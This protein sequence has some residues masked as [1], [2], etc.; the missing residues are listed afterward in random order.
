MSSSDGDRAA[1][2]ATGEASASAGAAPSTPIV[3][4]VPVRLH[5]G[6]EGEVDENDNA[7]LR[8]YAA[9]SPVAHALRRNSLLHL[10]QAAAAEAAADSQGQPAGSPAGDD[11]EES[12]EEEERG[13]LLRHQK[14]PKKQSSSS[15]ATRAGLGGSSAT[16]G[17]GS[18]SSSAHSSRLKAGREYCDIPSIFNS[19]EEDMDY[20]RG[21]EEPLLGEWQVRAAAAVVRH[22][23]STQNVYSASPWSFC[24]LSFRDAAAEQAFHYY[25]S[26]LNEHKLRRRLLLLNF[27]YMIYA[28]IEWGTRTSKHYS[29][30]AQSWI[31]VLRVFYIVIN[32]IIFSISFIRR[33][34]YRRNINTA[35][36]ILTL[37]TSTLIIWEGH[38]LRNIYSPF[39][40]IVLI[41]YMVGS[42]IYVRTLFT[43][44][45]G[46]CWYNLILYNFVCLVFNPTGDLSTLHSPRAALVQLV[47]YDLIL[48][49]FILTIMYQTRRVE[50]QARYGFLV[51]YNEAEEEEKQRE[52]E[53]QA[54][55]SA[56][57]GAGRSAQEV[58]SQAAGIE[59]ARGSNGVGTQE[60]KESS[61]I[62]QHDFALPDPAIP[63]ASSSGS[64]A[65]AVAAAAARPHLL[66]RTKAEELA[67]LRELNAHERAEDPFFFSKI[68]RHFL[69]RKP[70]NAPTAANR[71]S[72]T[73]RTSS[74][75][76]GR[77]RDGPNIGGIGSSSGRDREVDVMTDADFAGLI[78]ASPTLGGF[79]GPS[80]DG[81]DTVFSN[82]PLYSTL[83]LMRAKGITSMSDFIRHLS[84]QAKV[85]RAEN[86]IRD[87]PCLCCSSEL[88]PWFTNY[89]YVQTM[90]RANYTAAMCVRSIFQLH[91]ETVNICEWGTRNSAAGSGA[92]SRVERE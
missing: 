12:D 39:V 87:L 67:L 75:G 35:S 90:Y 15:A 60:H 3:A 91:N 50:K 64:G 26:Q 34:L 29:M 1:G 84:H 55:A 61:S 52:R 13:S 58:A 37:L 6:S 80:Q 51:Y 8:T 42:N 5:P 49:F 66:P 9:S 69:P 14:K 89:P 11:D 78:G 86:S 44:S 81:S 25:F 73:A 32:A 92:E 2:A 38:I 62:D 88:P 72:A 59:Q 31:T 56:E 47:Y 77:D 43:V 54:S 30:A 46:V 33:N 24:S 4:P 7:L 28:T 82:D 21:G 57:G 40:L 18:A 65:A 63:V 16:A 68:A 71:G 22:R 45:A 41:M 76:T 85:K 53:S 20:A 79:A 83:S 17:A 23:Q 27:L 74:E 70:K 48:V 36:T 19:T 10:S